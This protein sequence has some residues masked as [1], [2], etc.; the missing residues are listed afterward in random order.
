[1]GIQTLI[2]G[3]S[4]TKKMYKKTQSSKEA[5]NDQQNGDA[6]PSCSVSLS[7][8]NYIPAN[9]TVTASI[10]SSLVNILGRKAVHCCSSRHGLVVKDLGDEF[11]QY[12]FQKGQH[13]A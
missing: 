7:P 13:N 6:T 12:L 11:V 9:S 4:N 2:V 10:S 3:C 1:M 8:S 5:A